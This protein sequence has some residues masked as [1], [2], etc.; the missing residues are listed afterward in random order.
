MPKNYK[1]HRHKNIIIP[2]K[3]NEFEDNSLDS[4]LKKN[5]QQFLKYWFFDLKF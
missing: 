5:K 3:K 4:R 2:Y 1:Y